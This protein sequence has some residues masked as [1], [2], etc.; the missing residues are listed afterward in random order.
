MEY[1]LFESEFMGKILYTR[2]DHLNAR[3]LESMTNVQK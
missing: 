1:E 3:K 2:I